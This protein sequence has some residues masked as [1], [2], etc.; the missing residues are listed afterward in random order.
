MTITYKTTKTIDIEQLRALY[1]DVQWTAYTQDEAVL[2]AIVPNAL[3]V[4]SAWSDDE[5]VG[6][7]RAVGDGVYIL[8]IQDIL[9][10]EAYQGKGIGSTLLQKMLEANQMVRQTVLMTDYQDKTI[11]FYEKN[12][13]TKADNEKTGIAFVR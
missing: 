7:T 1:T 8:Y 2:K 6:L 11:Q 3:H 5:L 4:I 13:F 9:V 10:K 12:G